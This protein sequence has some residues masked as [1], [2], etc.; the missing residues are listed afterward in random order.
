[1]KLTSM[2]KMLKAAELAQME[3]AQL[4]LKNQMANAC[5]VPK[6]PIQLLEALARNVILAPFLQAVVACR[7]SRAPF[8]S[9]RACLLVMNAYQ[10]SMK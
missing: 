10:E 1:M 7:A 2:A 3:C 6:A 8:P 5:R 4:E 9:Y